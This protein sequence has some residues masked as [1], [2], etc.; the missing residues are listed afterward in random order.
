MAIALECERIALQDDYFVSR[1]LYPNVDLYTRSRRS[2]GR[3]RFI[4][5]TGSAPTLPLA[6][7]SSDS[8]AS[9]LILGLSGG[10]ATSTGKAGETDTRP[11]QITNKFALTS[12]NRAYNTSPRCLS[13]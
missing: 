13:E 4:G 3:T 1:R 2:P 5:A 8:I 12:R 10:R 9:V 7:E 11:F 6:S